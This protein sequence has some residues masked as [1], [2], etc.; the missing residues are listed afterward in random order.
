MKTRP[1]R[2]WVMGAWLALAILPAARSAAAGLS[3]F[4]DIRQVQERGALRVGLVAKD[5]PPLLVTGS[6]GQPAGIEVAMANGLARRLGVKLEFVRTAAT[7]DELVAQV[8]AGDVDVAVSSVTRT[9]ER[10][11][12]VRFSRPYLT[13]SVAVALNRVRALQENVGCPDTPAEAAALAA[14][15]GGLGVTRG[16]AYEQALRNRDK[17]TKPVLF[18][19]ERELQDA[20]ETDRLL[21]GFG[22]EIGLREL[23]ARRPAARIKLKLCLLGEKDQ[24]AIAVRPDA[25]NLAAWID[26]VLDNVGLQLSPSGIFTLGTDWTF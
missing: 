23:F 24:I 12:A 5:I 16:G 2:I 3:S 10:A 20:L 18:D 19:T 13:Q 1:W 14:R 25:S 7:H 15:P 11:Q 17:S 21:A 6:D 9:V 26:V 22:G 8:A 4:A